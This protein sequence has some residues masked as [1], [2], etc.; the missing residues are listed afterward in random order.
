MVRESRA[1]FHLLSE[2]KQSYLCVFVS[3]ADWALN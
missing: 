2:E 1:A 3:D